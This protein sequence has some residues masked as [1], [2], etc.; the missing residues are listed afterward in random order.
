VWGA[1]GDDEITGSWTDDN[2]VGGDGSDTIDG[3][4]GTDHCVAEHV[5][6][7]ES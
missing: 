2:L 5:T 7:C 6:N 1:A 4:R 3:L